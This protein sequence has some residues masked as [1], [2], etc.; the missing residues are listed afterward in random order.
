MGRGSHPNPSEVERRT[1][2]HPAADPMPPWRRPSSRVQSKGDRRPR[3]PALRPRRGLRSP[4]SLSSTVPLRVGG[5]PMPTFPIGGG[6]SSASS[7]SSSGC[8]PMRT[9]CPK[10]RCYSCKYMLFV[11]KHFHILH[12]Y[13]YL[14]I[15]IPSPAGPPTPCN[16]PIQAT[17]HGE[18]T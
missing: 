4:S 11:S 17:L 18:E 7:R 8:V 14:T 1:A 13:T 9:R 6:S 16:L 15:M 12:I 10:S 2:P 3:S 5:S